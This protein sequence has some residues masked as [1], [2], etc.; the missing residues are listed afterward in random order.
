MPGAGQ[1]ASEA[2]RSGGSDKPSMTAKREGC[3]QTDVDIVR[4][5]G[6]SNRC[7]RCRRPEWSLRP[8]VGDQDR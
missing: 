3:G 1:R 4:P 5:A 7:L 2:A 8:R 6:V